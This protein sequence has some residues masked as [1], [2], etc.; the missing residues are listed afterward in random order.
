VKIEIRTI[1]EATKPAGAR[2]I[3][4]EEPEQTIN[5]VA[6]DQ[7]LRAFFKTHNPDGSADEAVRNYSSRIVNRSYRA[8]FQAIELKRL[9]SRF[10]N[11]DMRTVA[12]D[13]RAKWL[14]MLREHAN[15]FENDN[16][17]L[18]QELQPIFFPGMASQVADDAV[19]QSDADLARAVERLH[20]L[21]LSNNEAISSGFAISSQSS[22]SPIKSPAFWQ[23]ILRAES[24]AKSIAQYQAAHD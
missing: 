1:A 17:V 10:A 14:A 3:T 19:L 21:A 2:T 24:L 12:P 4:L 22:S 13:A 8:L 7:D 16:A 20:K 5:T 11:V 9:V 18:R 6:A 15:A 23:S